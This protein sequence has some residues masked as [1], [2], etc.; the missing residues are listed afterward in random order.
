MVQAAAKTFDVLFAF[1][2]RYGLMTVAEVTAQCGLSRNQVY[3][4][5]KTLEAL[6]IVR[7]ETRGFRLTTKLL[8]LVPAMGEPALLAVAEPLLLE[9]RDATRETVNLVA[10]V[11]D[12]QTICLATYPPS[13]SI[14]LL[15]RPG[16]RSR[17]HAG[18]VPKA[19]LAFM[20]SAVIDRV[21]AALPDLPRYTERTELDPRR[22]L[23]E[24]RKIRERGFSV[25]N[26]DFEEGAR[27]V[28]VPIFGPDGRPL[29]GFSIGGPAARVDD[30][31]LARYAR[32]AL[33]T[34][35]AISQ[36]LGYRPDGI[37]GVEPSASH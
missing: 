37:H 34:S 24:L 28:G 5:L 27:G 10:P 21:L 29:G 22:L 36:R 33:S 7:E 9:L 30:A 16:Q 14:G 6:G 1:K 31:S 8:E 13:R 17:L 15:T 35:A 25:S 12:D 4:C 18:A 32:L 11:D 26:G 20:D 19:M 3:R 23:E 2:S